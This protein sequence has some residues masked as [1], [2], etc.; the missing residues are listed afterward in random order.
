DPADLIKEN[1]ESWPVVLEKAEPIVAFLLKTLA[2]KHKDA[3]AFKKEAGRSVLPYI[4]AMPSEI[5]KAHWVGEVANA[6]K[7]REENVWQELARLKKPKENAARDDIRPKIRN[8]K[9][10]LEE[11]LIG[12]IV[13]K[14]EVLN[15]VL[16]GCGSDWFAPERRP[17]FE[18]V[19]HAQSP[20]EDHYVKKLA[21]EAEV[22]CGEAS[23]LPLQFKALARDLKKEHLKERLVKLGESVKEFE[24]S[25]NKE[26]LEKKFEEFKA[27]SAELNSA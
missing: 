12:L 19:I 7:M 8:R 25:G 16:S 26:E 10:L 6:L 15:D 21:L 20:A 27:V 3:L 22:F 13:W 1:P 14:K 5:D 9:A 11:R 23:D 4:S 17:I 18:S 24:M 2:S